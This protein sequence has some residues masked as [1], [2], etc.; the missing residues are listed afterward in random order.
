MNASERIATEFPDLFSEAFD[1]WIPS[2]W[3]EITRQACDAIVRVDP[4]ARA[5]QL[6]EKFGGIRLYMNTCA[7][8][9]HTVI[10]ALEAQSFHTCQECGAPGTRT[11]KKWLVIT[12]CPVCAATVK[13]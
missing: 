6:K 7:Q 13:Q 11:Q 9:T 12:L 2:G 5:A 3:Y 10:E 4:T 8:T 1:V